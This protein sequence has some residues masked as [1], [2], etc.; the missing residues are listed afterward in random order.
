MTPDND[1]LAKL[2]GVL[3]ELAAAQG[4]SA[5]AMSVSAA[6]PTDSPSTKTAE[7]PPRVGAQQGADFL[8]DQAFAVFMASTIDRDL[9]ARLPVDSFEIYHANL[10]KE[11][12]SPTD[13]ILKMIAQQL[14][15]AHFTFLRLQVRV[16]H[17]KSREECGILGTTACHLMA[18]FRRSA[19][20]LNEI[21]QSAPKT[22]AD[23][24][25]VSARPSEANDQAA[26]KVE[27]SC[28]QAD[29]REGV[30]LPRREAAPK[31]E[32]LSKREAAAKTA[33][34]TEL[35]NKAMKEPDDERAA[36]T[37]PFKKPKP[38]RRRTAKSA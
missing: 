1:N 6:A 20:T 24:S 4:S 25:Q 12:G 11:L 10:L 34:R 23:A 36:D 31:A 5:T 28:E 22:T 3:T 15:V 19:T 8:R 21:R 9:A 13:P 27:P 29:D 2:S 38:R 16:A 35:G 30:A 26:P 32:E 37:V 7:A 17:A 33:P 18:E 14:V